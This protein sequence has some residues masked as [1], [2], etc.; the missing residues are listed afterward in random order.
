MELLMGAR[1]KDDRSVGSLIL[2]GLGFI[3]FCIIIQMVEVYAFAIAPNALSAGVNNAVGLIA[4]FTFMA[5]LV[6]PYMVFPWMAGRLGYET[7]GDH[8]GTR[9]DSI[10]WISGFLFMPLMVNFA[11]LTLIPD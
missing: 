7:M 11:V 8:H 6:V 10:Y 3:V 9:R 2:F 1:D 4:A 5:E